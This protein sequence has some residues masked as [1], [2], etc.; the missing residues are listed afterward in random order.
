MSMVTDVASLVVAFSSLCDL[1]YETLIVLYYFGFVNASFSLC[2][3]G[4]LNK[5]VE[6]FLKFKVWFVV[7]DEFILMVF[8]ERP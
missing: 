1:L 8:C 5:F 2:T 3:T 6:G 7:L 4:F